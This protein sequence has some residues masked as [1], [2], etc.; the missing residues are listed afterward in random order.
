MS[1][2]EDMRR[3]LIAEAQFL[4]EVD[5]IEV[6]FSG[7]ELVFLAQLIK[8]YV[9]AYLDEHEELDG[10]S[11]KFDIGMKSGLFEKLEGALENLQA[12][13][14]QYEGMESYSEVLERPIN[15]LNKILRLIER[16]NHQNGLGG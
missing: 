4:N 15:N 5:N 10:F 16:V 12:R 11:F 1:R 3:Q 8:D 13:F 14:D 9:V 7:N 2:S 6:E